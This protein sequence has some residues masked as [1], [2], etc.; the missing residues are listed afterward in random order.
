[1]DNKV[2]E[3]ITKYEIKRKEYFNGKEVVF[4]ITD[5]KILLNEIEILNSEITKTNK[6]IWHSKYLYKK[7]KTLL[8]YIEKN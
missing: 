1:M 4:T 7:A 5:I 2:D 6:T 3:V 8:K